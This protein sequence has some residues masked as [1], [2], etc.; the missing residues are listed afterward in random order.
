MSDNIKKINVDKKMFIRSVLDDSVKIDDEKRTITFSFASR[1]PYLRWFGYEII[2]TKNLDLTRLNDGAPILFNHNHDDY[3]GVCENAFYNDK[4]EKC[5][6]TARFDTHDQAVKIYNSIQNGVLK[7]VSFGYE[8]TS[9]KFISMENDVETY[10]VIAS[11][12]E[13]SIAPVPADN[14]VG[15][16]RSNDKDNKHIDI[17]VLIEKNKENISAK[18]EIDKNIDDNIEN[19]STIEKEEK[20]N[21]NINIRRSTMSDNVNKEVEQR[22][23]IISY[24]RKFGKADLALDF[25]ES[26]KSLDEFKDALLEERSSSASVVKNTDTDDYKKEG[27]NVGT[28]LKSMID[29][30]KPSGVYK[31]VNDDLIR[32]HGQSN[33]G[34]WLTTFDM[35]RSVT[36]ANP[37]SAGNFVDTIR[38]NDIYQPF[39]DELVLARS[40]A[41]ILTDLVGNQKFPKSNNVID[42]QYVKE[43]TAADESNLDTG[44]AEMT[45]KDL[46]ANISISRSMQKMTS[47]NL[48]KL[49][50]NQIIEKIA[51][52]LDFECLY[53]KGGDEIKGLVNYAGI[54]SVKTG[55]TPTWLNILELEAAILAGNNRGKKNYISNSKVMG[56]LKSI[57]K[58]SGREFLTDGLTMNNYDYYTTNMIKGVS[59]TVEEQT[60]ILNSLIMGSFENN[61]LIGQW[62]AVELKYD[63]NYDIKTGMGMF[64][65]FLT[66]D[67]TILNESGFAIASDIVV[68]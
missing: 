43:N 30:K 36:V 21:L 31:E 50:T 56:L 39:G 20:N 7:N 67:M 46:S 28:M 57:Q 17:E 41:T 26:G 62:G 29:G 12:Y 27:F 68:S 2:D 61:M 5:Y 24:G 64:V 59:T 33:D 16:G 51:E 6:V 14:S 13:V 60:K 10:E 3:I 18:V 11:A 49:V 19:T 32:K 4:D 63:P 23:A 35:L 55:G 34:S 66:A 38:H 58:A 47:L 22:N 40:G 15:I 25:I 9:V 65:A 53:G 45:G 1:Q 42:V 44:F 37:T 54:G 52:K 8:I 48:E